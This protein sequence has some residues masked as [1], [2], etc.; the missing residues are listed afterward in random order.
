MKYGY[1]MPLLIALLL[2]SGTVG[3]AAMRPVLDIE[4]VI[5]EL[6]FPLH[7]ACMAARMAFATSAGDV[8]RQ[9]VIEHIGT[10]A[11]SGTRQFFEALSGDQAGT[12]T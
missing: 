5:F 10:I 2:A 12:R 3:I 11:K 1:S 6:A 4:A 9:E 7:F 8:T